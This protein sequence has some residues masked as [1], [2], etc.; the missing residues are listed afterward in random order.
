M[1]AVSSLWD[2]MIINDVITDK[3]G[4]IA[5]NVA[6]RM[7]LMRTTERRGVT[8]PMS[9]PRNKQ[10]MPAIMT[11]DGVLGGVVWF[12]SGMYLF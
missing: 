7:R 4:K 10:P 3:K 12:L 5:L 9:M 2:P 8:Q 11:H 1:A 6:A